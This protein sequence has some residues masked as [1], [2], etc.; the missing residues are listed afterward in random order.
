M[1]RKLL[2]PVEIELCEMGLHG[3]YL[4]V[5]IAARAGVRKEMA[6]PRMARSARIADL[7]LGTARIAEQPSATVPG[8]STKSSHLQVSANRKGTDCC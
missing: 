3:F 8:P 4:N 2:T 1:T 6:K 5:M 7:N